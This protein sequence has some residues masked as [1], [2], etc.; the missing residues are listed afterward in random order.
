MSALRVVIG[1][2]SSGLSIIEREMGY[3]HRYYAESLDPSSSSK[4]DLYLGDELIGQSVVYWIS[5]R[6]EILG[7]IYYI[8]VDKRFRN[9]GFGKILVSSS[10]NYLEELGADII[11]ASM[12]EDNIASIRVFEDLGYALYRWS[13]LDDLCKNNFSETLLRATCG[14]ED[15]YIA[16]KE[17]VSRTTSSNTHSLCRKLKSCIDSLQEEI[18]SHWRRHCYSPWRRIL[19]TRIRN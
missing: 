9:R 13:D 15:D 6:G 17:I 1:E 11:A 5:G 7:V 3:I 16:I 19:R 10:E 18:E 14:Y 4:L 8:A 2:V 12:R